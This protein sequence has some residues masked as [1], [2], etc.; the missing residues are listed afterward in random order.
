MDPTQIKKKK[1]GSC[2]YLQ[3]FQNTVFYLKLFKNTVSYFKF[4]L[5]SVVRVVLRFLFP[6]IQVK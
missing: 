6:L 4:L 5:L 2:I 1:R 3:I